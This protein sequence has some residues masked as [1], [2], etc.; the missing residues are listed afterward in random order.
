MAILAAFPDRVARRRQ[1][2][3]L[4]LSGGGSAILSPSTTV[5]DAPF[6]VAIDIEE[7]QERGLPLV[8]LASAI[9]PDWLLDLFPDRVE[10]RSGVEWNRT[11]ERVE[12]VSALVYDGLVIEE[13]RGGA[14]DPAQAGRLLAAKARE[15]G[16]ARFIDETELASFRARVQFASQHS[17]IAAITDDDVWNSVEALC[18]GLRSFR[19]LEQA[20]KDGGLVR[21]LESTRNTRLL[22][23]IAP[24]RL[25]L[26]SGRT[27]RIEYADG[28][29]PRAGARLQEFFGMHETP[30][31]AHGQVPL[32]LLLLAPSQRPV[33]TTSDLKGFWEKWYPQVRRE[34]M[35]R[36]PKHAW[37]ENPG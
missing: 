19:E 35:R 28:Q 1:R 33:Q 7:R 30:R 6:L 9:E 2:D 20:L 4:L 11:G 29:P 16:L 31:I 27:V 22:E 18:A 37:P 32:V 12:S 5:R 24:A 25:K 13:S 17:A 36:Y 26:P 3:E 34:L 15:T 21:H 14:V 10:A 23:E 8:R